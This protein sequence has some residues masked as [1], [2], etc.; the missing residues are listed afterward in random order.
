MSVNKKHIN[1]GFDFNLVK[2]NK[3]NDNILFNILYAIDIDEIT[4]TENQI[5]LEQITPKII[6]EVNSYNKTDFKAALNVLTDMEIWQ[7]VDSDIYDGIVQLF[8][9]VDYKEFIKLVQSQS[10]LINPKTFLIAFLLSQYSKYLELQLIGNVIIQQT[11]Y[12][13]SIDSYYIDNVLLVSKDHKQVYMT[14]DTEFL[15][16]SYCD[17]VYD[18]YIRDN[19]DETWL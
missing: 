10:N 15:E 13:V 4:Y 6:E 3:L 12:T 8:L 17:M 9:E 14:N 16:N 5:V 19:V 2:T 1:E 11:L 18:E 7:V